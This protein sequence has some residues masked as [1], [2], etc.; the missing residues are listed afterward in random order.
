ML[1]RAAG[2]MAA[3][4]ARSSPEDP[5]GDPGA[6]V[7]RS[8]GLGSGIVNIDP[9]ALAG[10][11]NPPQREAVLY[12]GGPL[13]VFAGAGSGKTRVITHRVANLVAARGV[14]AWN[15]LAVTFTNKAAGEMRERLEHMLGGAAARDLW[16]GT[17]HATC[18]RLLRRYA[19]EVGI[20]RDFTIYDDADQRAMIKRVLRDVSLDEKRFAPKLVAGRIN[21]S[22]QEVLGP[23]QVV[24][25]DWWDEHVVNVYR[26]Y[27]ERMRAANALDF[28]DLL[29]RLVSWNSSTSRCRKRRLSSARK[30]ASAS[31]ATTSR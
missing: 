12:E 5:S 22:K 17:F 23:D 4:V 18:A 9:V 21:R 20:K 26:V 30:P 28:G 14:A 8:V 11:L 13:V 24:V 6:G 27:E 16:V 1:S 3:F 29:Y 2:F 10:S 31:S 25:G 7:A 19:A 15:V